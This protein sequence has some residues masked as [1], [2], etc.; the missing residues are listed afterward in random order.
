MDKRERLTQLQNAHA[1]HV[2][3]LQQ[4]QANIIRIEGALEILREQIADEDAAALPANVVPINRKRKPKIIDVP[5][6]QTLA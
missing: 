1:Q 2:Q 5:A 3:L 6:E 4:T